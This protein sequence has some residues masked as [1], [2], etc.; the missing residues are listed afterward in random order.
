[1]KKYTA[2]QAETVRLEQE[3]E[4]EKNIKLTITGENGGYIKA[5]G[6]DVKDIA[7]T[8]DTASKKYQTSL[9]FDTGQ[10]K[11]YIRL[12]FTSA[13]TL[14]DPKYYPT[15]ALLEDMAETIS[16]T[17]IVPADYLKEFFLNG[18]ASFD[19]AYRK[20]VEEYTADKER[21]RRVLKAAEGEL[22]LELKMPITER[23][24]YEAKTFYPENFRSNL[25]Q[26]QLFNMPVTEFIELELKYS[27]QKLAT[28][29]PEFFIVQKD[30]GIIEFL[31]LPYGIPVVIHQF[32]YSSAAGTIYPLM[33]TTLDRI[34]NFFHYKYKAGLYN[35][36]ASHS[37]KEALRMAVARRTLMNIFNS[38]DPIARK[39]SY[40]ENTDGVQASVT[41]NA[42]DYIKR[43]KDQENEFLSNMKNKYG[44][45]LNIAIA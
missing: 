8:Y 12:Y 35:D 22:E 1:M 34:P 27:N 31:P 45:N 38:I 19:P 11:Q 43:L 20:A 36:A 16:E 37:E 13:D 23:M 3:V 32:L 2:G 41:Y 14:I 25:W 28:F 6:A 39:N 42:G 15:D 29:G 5:G 33:S 30:T 26:Q 7:L 4:T 10:K 24:F 18:Q 44:Q 40:S 17:E 21:I 9:T